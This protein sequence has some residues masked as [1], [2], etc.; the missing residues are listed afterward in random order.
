M[1][2]ADGDWFTIE[3]DGRLLIPVFHSS[4]D[5]LMARLRTTEMLLFSPTALD[6]QLFNDIVNGP[7]KVDFCM[8]ENPFASL[9]LGRTLPHAQVMS[10]ISTTPAPRRWK[11]LARPW[12]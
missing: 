7:S 2:R 3:D 10:L 11:W 12:S 1:R 5:A 4:H 6:V 9:K 8:V